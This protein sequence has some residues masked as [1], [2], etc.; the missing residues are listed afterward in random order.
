[1]CIGLSL[2]KRSNSSRISEILL[3]ERFYEPRR[4]AEQALGTRTGLALVKGHAVLAW[5]HRKRS[6]DRGVTRLEPKWREYVG[7]IIF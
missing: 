1:M 2:S 7:V 6:V 3:Y 4:H 5:R